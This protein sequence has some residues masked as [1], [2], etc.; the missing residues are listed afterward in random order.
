MVRT[1]EVAGGYAQRIAAAAVEVEDARDALRLAVAR[2]NELLVS[3]VDQG[4]TQT[5]AAKFAGLKP[6]S[7]IAILAASYAD[8]EPALP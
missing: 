2:R 7:L 1:A 8:S 6:P 5:A 3:A 4:M